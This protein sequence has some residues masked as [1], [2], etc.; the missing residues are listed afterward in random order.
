MSWW[1]RTKSVPFRLKERGPDPTTA[2]I[3]E[4]A[5]AEMQ[6]ETNSSLYA[7]MEYHRSTCLIRLVGGDS[8]TT[9]VPGL[10]LPREDLME[11][12]AR[13]RTILAGPRE[14]IR[15]YDSGSR[16]EGSILLSDL[17][18]DRVPRPEL[19]DITIETADQFLCHQPIHRFKLYRDRIGNYTSDNPD[20]NWEWSW[21]AG[22]LRTEL[23]S[24]FIQKGYG[25]ALPVAYVPYDHQEA[26]VNHAIAHGWDL[27]SAV[28]SAQAI[29]RYGRSPLWFKKP[30]VVRYVLFPLP[31]D[32][33]LRRPTRP[34]SL[35]PFYKD[36]KL[37][38]PFPV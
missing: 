35:D 14:K 30:R 29:V 18:D 11:L 15:I 34:R 5:T 22:E 20:T 7:R 1:G 26:A 10:N 13:V 36:V 16:P 28:E 9:M 32:M 17:F 19:D 25:W 8:L 12:R 33:L 27:D 3:E 4:I 6:W 31:K 24:L 2:S 23:E 37:N 38:G 21:N